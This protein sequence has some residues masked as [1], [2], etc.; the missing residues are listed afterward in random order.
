MARRFDHPPSAED[1]ARIAEDALARVPAGLRRHVRGIAILVREFA[2]DEVLEDLGIEDPFEL[3][4]LYQGVA[5]DRR[6]SWDVREDLDRIYLYRRPLLEAWAEGADRL[7]DLVANTLIHEIGHHF[8][9]SDEDMEK[10][11]SD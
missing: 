8:G 3:L 4:G 11:E 1:I 10:L 6:S 7:E 5:M 9:L 2:E